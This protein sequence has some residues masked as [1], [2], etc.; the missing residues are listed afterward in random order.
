MRTDV[1]ENLTL[2]GLN[3]PANE[4]V[5]R[6]LN[7]AK[8]EIVAKLETINEHWFSQR[9]DYT[10]S[11]GD[12]SITLPDGTG[13]DYVCRRVLS[14]TVVSDDVE[15]PVRIYDWNDPTLH[16]SEAGY[17]LYLEGTKLYFYDAGG[18]P[19]TGTLRLRYAAAVDDL[20]GKD[21][22]ETFSFIPAELCDLIVL[23]ATIELLPGSAKDAHGKY[24]A[25]L[26]ERFDSALRLGQRP[27]SDGPAGIKWADEYW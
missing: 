21:N 18:A 27:V 16:Q 15:T 10:V 23:T 20:T 2:E 11:S 8:D 7:R 4:R 3:P 17:S 1:T 22:E 5:L 6:A 19:E 26:R 13:T 25:R 14:L 24:E 9:K 12:A